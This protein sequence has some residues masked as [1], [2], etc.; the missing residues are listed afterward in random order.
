MR[1]R[2]GAQVGI[3]HRPLDHAPGDGIGAV[4]DD[5]GDAPARGLFQHV[6]QRRQVGVVADTD[7]L[8]IEDE[9]VDARQ[10]LG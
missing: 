10:H 1:S 8:D 6:H 9:G 2:E 7:V 4:Q 3:H 5:D